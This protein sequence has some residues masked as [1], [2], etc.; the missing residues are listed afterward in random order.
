MIPAVKEVAGEAVSGF[1]V[2]V[3]GKNGS[4]GYRLATPLDIFVRPDEAAEIAS[5]IILLF[6]DFGSRES[7]NKSRLA[8]LVEEWGEAFFR[9]ELEKRAGRQLL[10]AGIDKRDTRKKTDHVGIFRQKQPGMNYIGLLVPVG[11]MTTGQ[12]LEVGRLAE[13]YGTG[14]IRLTPGQ[15][16]IL[17]NIPDARLGDL[18]EE[19]LLKDL[20]YHPSEIMRGLVSCTGI[21]YCNLAVIETKNRALK[22]ARAL[23]ARVMTS[24]PVTIHWSGCPAGC[25]NHA[26]ADIGLLGKKMKMNGQVVD[27]V[28]IFV[29]GRSGPHAQQAVKVMEDIPCDRLEGVLEGL[30]LHVVREKNVEVLKGEKLSTLLKPAIVPVQPAS[31]WVNVSELKEFKEKS[32]KVVEIA[33]HSVAIFL[34][35]GQFY[36]VDA[37]CP[38]EGG[39]LGEGKLNG[40]EVIC[41]LHGYSFHLK[42]GA[43]ST[44][45]G[46]RARTYPVRLEGESLMI[47][48]D[49]SSSCTKENRIG[50]GQ[51]PP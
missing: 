39:A 26:V 8:F 29:G 15:N 18:A 45:K 43:C 1:N 51:S 16:I 7:R 25:G 27:G 23:E 9:E 32:T 3:G 12:L 10:R 13:A 5:R 19:P 47:Q 38:H 20:T 40:M 34:V 4:G 21:E 46:L 22:I 50:L 31:R 30:A 37:V 14:E 42:T 41:P 28:D 24:K 36:A 11:R 35:D 44:E 17:P 2:L 6:R 33:G 48:T 49:G